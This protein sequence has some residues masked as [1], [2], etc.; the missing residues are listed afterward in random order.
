MNINVR[1]IVLTLI[2]FLSGSI[3]YPLFPEGKGKGESVACSNFLIIS[4]E[5]N[6]NRF[7]FSFAT[8]PDDPA[9]GLNYRS[10]QNGTEI[11]IP[12]R[13]FKA[14]NPHMYY[15]FLRQLHENDYPYISIRFPGFKPGK[16]GD[17]A[18]ESQYSVLIT[19]AGIKKQYTIDCAV[20]TCGDHYAISGSETLRLTDFNISPPEKL[21]GLIKV[22]DEINVSFGIILNF[23]QDKP[24]AD[25]R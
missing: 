22:K 3:I 20:I 17:L 14:S 25:L 5:S 11:M 15:D 12:V 9:S 1:N 8:R 6:I 21:N 23:T 16:P 19:L 4:G 7:S 24:Y 18:K 13:D 2:L 10:W